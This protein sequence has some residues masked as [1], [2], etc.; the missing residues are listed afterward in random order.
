MDYQNSDPG[1][2]NYSFV[3][4]NFTANKSPIEY[5]RKKIP[6]MKGNLSLKIMKNQ[7]F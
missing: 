7:L 5:R 3:F 6:F 2:K 1:N 4:D